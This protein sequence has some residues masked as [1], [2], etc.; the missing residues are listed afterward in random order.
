MADRIKT[1]GVGQDYL[2]LILWASSEGN[3]NDGDRAVALV[4]ENLL[5]PSTLFRPNQSFPNGGLIKGN[6]TVTGEPGVGV[7]ITSLASSRMMLQPTDNIDYEDLYMTPTTQT[8]CI[9]S[10][11][12]ARFDRVII[13]GDEAY[14][15]VLLSDKTAIINNSVIKALRVFTSAPNSEFNLNNTLVT[16]RIIM[17]PSPSLLVFKNSISTADEFLLGRGT[18]VDSETLVN[19]AKIFENSPSSDFGPGSDNFEVNYDSNNDFIDF[20][21]K[22][23]RIKITSPLATAGENGTFIGPFLESGDPVST[24]KLHWITNFSGVVS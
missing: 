9:Q 24:F 22:D 2:D 19:Y 5:M 20:A 7:E 8:Y 18:Y 23:Y 10:C 16:E 4:V 6:V 11:N 14:S 21:G 1:I 12:N 13:A 3:I 15:I 17:Q